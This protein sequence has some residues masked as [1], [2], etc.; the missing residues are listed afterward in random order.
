MDNKTKKKFH[1]ARSQ[2]RFIAK[3][4]KEFDI[5]LGMTSVVDLYSADPII[6]V[7]IDAGKGVEFHNWFRFSQVE[8]GD[9]FLDW[10]KEYGQKALDQRKEHEAELNKQVHDL[11]LKARPGF[12]AIESMI[13]GFGMYFQ[14]FLFDIPKTF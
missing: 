9:F 7:K 1:R 6:N 12:A 4:A 3:Q 5:D 2:F 14:I 11:I 10:V 13:S 8:D